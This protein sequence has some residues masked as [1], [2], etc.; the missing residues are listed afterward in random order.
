MENLSHSL[1]QNKLSRMSSHANAAA[2]GIYDDVFGG[3]PKF[4]VPASLSP[5]AEDYREIFGSFHAPRVSSIPVLDLPVVD[6]KDVCFDVR[7]P[8]FDYSEV[9]GGLQGLDFAEGYE[10]LFGLRGG[11]SAGC[12]SSD[13]VWTPAASETLSEESDH[14]GSNQF[15]WNG[16]SHHMY[17]KDIQYNISYQKANPRFDVEMENG[18]RHA[19]EMYAVP[20]YS[21]MVDQHLHLTVEK[22]LKKT[23]SDNSNGRI[24]VRHQ[25]GCTRINSCPN[26]SFV[27]ISG[28]S[29]RTEPSHL[30]P[31]SRVPPVALTGD[32]SGPVSRW[33]TGHVEGNGDDCCISSPYYDGEVDASSSAAAVSSATAMKEVMMK[34]QA[35]LRSAKEMMER[36]DGRRNRGRTCP[37]T[38]LRD[39][40]G[41]HLNEEIIQG[42]C[43]RQSNGNK[44]FAGEESQDVPSMKCAVQD[45]L[46]GEKLRS[47]LKKRLESKMGGKKSAHGQLFGSSEEAGHWNEATQFFELVKADGSGVVLAQRK[48][49]N[50]WENG[51]NCDYGDEEGILGAF[52]GEENF[53]KMKVAVDKRAPKENFGADLKKMSQKAAQE[54]SF[55]S[56]IEKK[57]KTG[58]NTSE[59]EVKRKQRKKYH[60]REAVAKLNGSE[61]SEGHESLNDVLIEM[62]HEFEARQMMGH[63]R[64]GPK[65]KMTARRMEVEEFVT[66]DDGKANKEKIAKEPS[67]SEGKERPASVTES[68]GNDTI[69][70]E[71]SRQDDEENRRRANM[72]F[73]WYNTCEREENEGRLKKIS[74]PEENEKKMKKVLENDERN[75]LT[76]AQELEENEIRLQKN[77]ALGENRGKQ[78]AALREEQ[79]RRLKEAFGENEGNENRLREPSENEKK[80]REAHEQEE[81]R[82]R[83]EALEKEVG[84]KIMKEAF[85]KEEKNILK[86]TLEKEKMLKEADEQKESQKKL[87]DAHEKEQIRDMHEE[88]Q[89]MNEDEGILEESCNREHTGERFPEAMGR[90]TSENKEK[91]DGSSRDT[92]DL[93][94]L[95]KWLKE[96]IDIEEADVLNEGAKKVDC[97]END[98]ESV[99]SDSPAPSPKQVSESGDVI[100]ASV[101]N[102]HQNRTE[103]H[104]SGNKIPATENAEDENETVDYVESPPLV[105]EPMQ[106]KASK[107][108]SQTINIS[109]H[110][111]EKS[112]AWDRGETEENINIAK[113]SFG[114]DAKRVETPKPPAFNAQR[115]TQQKQNVSQETAKAQ[116]K[117][118]ERLRKEEERL[119]KIEEERER[120]REREREKDRMAV[121]RA[122]LEARERAYPE[123]RERASRTTVERVAAE[124]RERLEKTC[125]EAR[126]QSSLD[127]TSHDARIRAERA[128]VERAI[129]EA[130]ERAASRYN[131]MRQSSIPSDHGE[132]QHQ[133]TG[134]SSNRRYEYFS[135]HGGPYSMGKSEGVEAESAQRCK[136][137]LE[138]HRRTAE[139]AVFLFFFAT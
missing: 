37:T 26:E 36:K 4:G 8:G 17:D 92:F 67:E 7:S 119:R 62:A 131:G 31:P 71:S 61:S 45:S 104:S 127:K 91:I 76:A 69:T 99:L 5:R 40:R 82:R 24:D 59:P 101:D 122:T 35:Q 134:S 6:K 52:D 48:G 15:H 110:Q 28:V 135:G 50:L 128:A 85:E 95:D 20:G 64:D 44:N 21:Y 97:M 87:N 3:P 113:P 33:K 103:P 77:L 88:I 132:W 2:K 93:E 129:A 111:E 57:N 94:E 70:P 30:P 107:V 68:M 12:G 1:R 121:D 78:E 39:M 130:R 139:R 51:E 133:T 32:K 79:E 106:T 11:G 41:K 47:S 19:T 29:L 22:H 114:G 23:R 63:K 126:D 14:S 105:D 56:N 49:H 81:E 123:A 58:Q 116:V 34:A 54:A 75:V 38:E 65:M 118:T 117:E 102:N 60:H 124:A 96:S 137:R 125:A 43:Q 89:K 18:L 90:K 80:L 10:E 108:P 120:E 74:V 27:T 72:E 83:K 42:M 112:S 109:R 25:R 53:K 115:T 98:T 16:D 138:R 84:K 55:G 46:E 73:A 136:A 86:E 66:E 9:F 100:D 13:E